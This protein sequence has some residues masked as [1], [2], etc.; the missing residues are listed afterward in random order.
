MLFQSCFL[1]DD[2]PESQESGTRFMRALVLFYIQIQKRRAG[3]SQGYGP[4]NG[5]VP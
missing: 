2:Y 4:A 3:L 5:D 1:S